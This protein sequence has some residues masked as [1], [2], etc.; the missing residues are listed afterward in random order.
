MSLIYL[1]IEINLCSFAWRFIF[2]EV[3]SHIIS[4]GTDN[5]CYNQFKCTFF[6]DN[7]YVIC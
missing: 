5:K 3:S 7:P 6:I 1:R 2:I 4:L